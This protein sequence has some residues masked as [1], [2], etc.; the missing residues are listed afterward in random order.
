MGAAE[1]VMEKQDPFEELEELLLNMAKMIVD[2]PEEVI[3]NPAMGRGFVA[4]EVICDD[5]DTGTLIGRRGKH[6]EAIRTM[7]MAAGAVR[8]IR[9][10]VQIVSR[11]HDGLPPR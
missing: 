4:F 2:Q 8:D 7:M 9:V 11:D 6:A 5:T 1:K 3:V 10:T